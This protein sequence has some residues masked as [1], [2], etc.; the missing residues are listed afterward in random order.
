MTSLLLRALLGVR[1]VD[2]SPAV[3][4]KLTLTG[5]SNRPSAWGGDGAGRA[6]L[7]LEFPLSQRKVSTELQ[8]DMRGTEQANLLAC[9]R[10]T[11]VDRAERGIIRVLQEHCLASRAR[12]VGAAVWGLKAQAH[13]PQC[14]TQPAPEAGGASELP[15]GE[16]Q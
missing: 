1:G 9:P 6:G 16:G 15:W 3:S 13:C 10:V 14:H 7:A 2:A 11:S 4:T 8:K 12:L 5:F